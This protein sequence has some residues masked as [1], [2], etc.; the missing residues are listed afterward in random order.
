M[1]VSAALWKSFKEK[2][3]ERRENKS[4]VNTAPDY[5]IYKCSFVPHF[6]LY[7]TIYLIPFVLHDHINKSNYVKKQKFSNQVIVSIGWGMYVC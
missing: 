1:F 4:F 3:L 6:Y 7:W 5:Y 2:L